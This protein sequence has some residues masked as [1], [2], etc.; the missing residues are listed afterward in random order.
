MLIKIIEGNDK[1]LYVFIKKK[2]NPWYL[3]TLI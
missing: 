2:E 1:E 3:L